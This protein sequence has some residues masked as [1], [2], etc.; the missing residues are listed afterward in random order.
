MATVEGTI[1]SVRGQVVEVQFHGAQP[2]IHDLLT[3]KDDPLTRLEVFSFT[4]ADTTLCIALSKIGNLFRGAQ[5]VDTGSSITIPA[6]DKVLGRIVDIFGQP[7]DG[8][9]PIEAQEYWSIYSPP[10]SY[11]SVSVSRELLETGIRV[12]DF[13]TP[14]IRGGKIGFFGGAGVGK[15]VLLTELMHNVTKYHSGVSVFAGIGERIREGHELY[16]SLKE[17]SVLPSTALVFGQMNEVAPVRYRVGFAALR[18]AEYFRDYQKRDVLFFIDNTFRFVQAGNEL[19]TLMNTLPSEDGYQP[20]LTSEMGEF[21]E[22][23]VSANTG[24]ITAIE[25]IYV[26]SDDITDQGVQA[27]YPYLDSVVVL[28]RQVADRGFRP[29]IDLLSSTSSVLNE[30]LVGKDH[31]EAAAEA[32]RML[33]QYVKLERIVSIVG[34]S[35]LSVIDRA[36]YQ[37]V[38]KL[39]RYMTQYFF[40]AEGQTGKPGVYVKRETTVRDVKAILT[41]Q[42]DEIPQEKFWYI[43]SLDSIRGQTVVKSQEV[44]RSLPTTNGASEKATLQSTESSKAVKGQEANMANG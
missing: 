1:V 21:Q 8:G 31:V 18:F 12:I 19:A 30:S 38:E 14:F 2:S 42:V 44:A 13:F 28:S 10:P 23:I 22:R 36:T 20:T 37:R 6:T 7:Q 43:E 25:A 40:V 5:V 32:L 9:G 33:K 27:I 16:E 3:L 35:E 26:P 15:T 11:E 4:L 34:E 17:T 29:A 41:G 24:S 39:M